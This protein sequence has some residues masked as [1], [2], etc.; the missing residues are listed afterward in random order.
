MSYLPIKT[1]LETYSLSDYKVRKL[2]KEGLIR[3]DQSYQQGMSQAGLRRHRVYLLWEEDI[4]DYLNKVQRTWITVGKAA[5]VYNV[6]YNAVRYWM[7]QGMVRSKKQPRQM[8]CRE[9]CDYYLA[10][11]VNKHSEKKLEFDSRG[12]SLRNRP[13]GTGIL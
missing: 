5:M 9:D 6:T 12:C 7:N 3:F 11:S 10:H 13:E 1:I 2:L 4:R 8:V